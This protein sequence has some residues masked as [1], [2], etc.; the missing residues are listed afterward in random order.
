MERGVEGW[1]GG[2]EI[3]EGVREEGGERGK[4]REEG[5]RERRERV[6]GIEEERGGERE[7]R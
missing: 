7:G 2:K 1:D 6:E 5:V 3:E 4:D